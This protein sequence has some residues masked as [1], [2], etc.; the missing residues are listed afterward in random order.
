MDDVESA[1][2]EAQGQAVATLTRILGDLTLAEDAVQDTF[3]TAVA[4]WPKDGV[5]ANPAGWIVTAARNRA[6]DVIRRNRRG[7][8]LTEQVATDRLRVEGAAGQEE[9]IQ[10][11][12]DQLR[13]I[14]TCCHPALRIE[15]QVALALRLVAG[16]S[17]AEV[18]SAFL[19]SEEAMAKRLV[20]A[21]L[22]S[23]RLWPRGPAC[24]REPNTDVMSGLGS[25]CARAPR[26]S[27]DRSRGR[28][29]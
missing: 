16:H 14:F 24:L 15:H 18:A 26:A 22:C 20:R 1:F 6:V 13:L 5:P 12:D 11:P 29:R 4:S 10:L 23:G 28:A 25:A 9:S 19:V 27:P 3:V 2:R 17:P 7:R 21:G 8:Q